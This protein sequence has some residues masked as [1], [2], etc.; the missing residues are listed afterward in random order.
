MII[1]QATLQREIGIDLSLKA[2][3]IG[4]TSDAIPRMVYHYAYSANSNLEGYVEFSLS[5]FNTSDFQNASV[6]DKIPPI[7]GGR[8][9]YCW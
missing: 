3:I 6:P 1:I 7:F 4:Y 8:V 2:F 5:K 9:E